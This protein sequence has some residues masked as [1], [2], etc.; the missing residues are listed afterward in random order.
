MRI[1]QALHWLKDTLPSDRD[2]VVARL[3]SI[4][5]DP[6]HGK[7]LSDDLRQG[8]S[9]L[10]RVDAGEDCARHARMFFNTPDFDLD[11]AA[12][13][14]LSLAPSAPMLDALERDYGAMGG[15]IMGP[16]PAFAD[17]MPSPRPSSNGSTRELT[18]NRPICP[19]RSRS[20]GLLRLC[21]TGRLFEVEAWIRAG[22]SLEVLRGSSEGDAREGRAGPLANSCARRIPEQLGD[23]SDRDR[24]GPRPDGRADV[25][26]VRTRRRIAQGGRAPGWRTRFDPP[27]GASSP[28]QVGSTSDPPQSDLRRRVHLEGTALRRAPSAAHFEKSAEV[29]NDIETPRRAN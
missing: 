11:Q 8:L 5:A 27:A 9:T 25:R 7:T 1:V 4:L 21:E 2:R 10:P 24:P 15:M 22:R 17:V 18:A 28:R 6:K 3:S 19:V 16:V 12:P 13:G 23:A 26:V 29:V 20:K 14:T